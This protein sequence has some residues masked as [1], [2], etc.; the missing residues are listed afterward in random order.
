[1][2][3]KSEEEGQRREIEIMKINNSENGGEIMA[4]ILSNG[5]ISGNNMAK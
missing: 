4:A 3:R 2:T 5:V 1:V